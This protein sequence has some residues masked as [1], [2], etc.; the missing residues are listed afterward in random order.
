MLVHL[1][2]EEMEGRWIAHAAGWPGCFASAET[3]EAAL[4][5]AP[6]AVADYLAWLRSHGERAPDE[7]ITVDVDEVHRAW[8]IGPEYEVSA[9][10]AEDR[11]PLAEADIAK[12]QR[13]L[14]WTRGDLLNAVQGLTAEQRARPVPGQRWPLD[15]ILNHVGGAEWWYLDRLGLA[16]PR[17]DVPDDPPARLEKV[18]AHLLSVLP[19][20]VGDERVVEKR[21]ELWTP[22][23]VL[24]RALWHERDHTA[25]IREL[26]PLVEAP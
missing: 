22:R 16:F 25:H 12:A 3:R 6:Q 19:Q 7:R 15:G 26:R 2:V 17:E 1:N 5:D 21:G 4:A 10:F 13:L 24:R 11:P 23:K 8:N 9:F 20:L 14:A 18:R